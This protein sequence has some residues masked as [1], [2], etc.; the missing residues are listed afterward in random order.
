MHHP[1]SSFACVCLYI[2]G[3]K[4]GTAGGGGKSRSGGGTIVVQKTKARQTT[5]V[6]GAILTLRKAL[7]NDDGSNK[8]VC[9]GIAP[10]FMCYDRKG[11]DVTIDFTSK[12]SKEETKWAFSLIKETMEGKCTQVGR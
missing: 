12:L 3:G 6:N 5:D 8:N 7:F 10:A 9:Q 1:S 11:L 2:I 4:G